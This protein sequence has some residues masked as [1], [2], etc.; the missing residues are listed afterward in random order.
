MP[1]NLCLHQT[2]H[3]VIGVVRRLRRH[4]IGEHVAEDTPGPPLTFRWLGR[5][6]ETRQ[7]LLPT[8]EFAPLSEASTSSVLWTK[9]STIEL[10]ESGIGPRRLKRLFN[11][12]REQPKSRQATTGLG[13]INQS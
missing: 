1:R 5:L 7:L 2:P 9:S 11:V 8:S 12:Y 4:T 6:D 3:R 13:P 10:Y